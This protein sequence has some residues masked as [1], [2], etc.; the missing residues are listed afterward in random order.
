MAWRQGYAPDIDEFQVMAEQAFARLPKEICSQ[1][2]NV[3]L[4]VAEFPDAATLRSM[5]L[6]SPF[7]LLGLY[8][9]V[10]LLERSELDLPR[11]PDM[12]FLYRRPI[13]EEWASRSDTLE[14][15]I[16]HV[17]VHEIGHH[18]GLSDSDMHSVER[19]ADSGSV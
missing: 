5:G 4:R 10:S 3:I 19:E 17:L 12:I 9:G 15:L 2:G 7:E 18:F 11:G 13:L 16:T 14:A 6:Q 8:H 1:L